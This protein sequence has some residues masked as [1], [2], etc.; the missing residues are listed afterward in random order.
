MYYPG[1]RLL[2]RGEVASWPLYIYETFIFILQK[3][4]TE[5]E[6]EMS[7]YILILKIEF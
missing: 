4:H 5:N 3:K 6:N 1:T 7:I 2:E